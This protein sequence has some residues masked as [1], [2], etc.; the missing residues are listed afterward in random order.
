[1]RGAAAALLSLCA[2]LAP[3]GVRAVPL[4]LS[5][6]SCAKYEA[7]IAST[8][9][10]PGLDPIDTV[11]W[12]FGFSVAKSGERSMFG[13]SLPA[14]G[15]ALDGDCKSNPAASLL[16]TVAAVKSK[17]DSP[18][19]L[20]ALSCTAFVTRHSAL[21]K[22]DAESATTLSMWLYGYA[23]ALVDGHLLDAE[24]SGK[25]E[26][27]LEAHCVAHPTDSLFDALSAP[28]SAVA[29]PGRSK[30]PPRPRAPAAAPKP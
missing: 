13:D 27:E 22:T 18:M 6:M 25:F 15:F 11:M 30:A 24:S 28:N 7:G 23:V 19:D 8:G 2:V 14:F 17:R 12:L 16:P 5:A 26:S 4:D 3:L 21:R 29:P 10:A 9:L 20:T 1:M